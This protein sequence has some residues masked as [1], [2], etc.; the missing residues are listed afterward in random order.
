[1]D[2]SQLSDDEF[3]ALRNIMYEA[4]GVKLLVTKKPLVI[5]R[6][7]KRLKELEID[8]FK[9][10]LEMIDKPHSKEMEIFIN[11]ITT[12]ETFFYRHPE[13]F[14]FL[15][16]T[17]FPSLLERE[18]TSGKPELKVWSAGCST[19]EE[20]YSVAIACK[21]FF[22]N[23]PQWN[24]II[25]AADINSAVLD[26]CRKGVYSERSVERMPQYLRKQYFDVVETDTSY[27]GQQ[28]YLHRDIVHSVKFLQHNLLTTF[29]I[30]NFDIIFLR[31]V[32]IYFDRASKQK[33]VS[34]IERNLIQGGYFFT[35]MAESLHDIRSHLR[36]VYT[37]IYQKE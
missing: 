1:M 25:Y 17:I 26:F 21:E 28:F 10:Y 32:M 30:G 36:F 13:H 3:H 29:P 16:K 14:Y 22:K 24:I 35:S 18:E 15:T 2:I 7:R 11:A 8:N 6:L 19:G 37:G 4:S 9:D 31:N 12:N 23:H 20:P 5:S 33:V 27:K 34:L